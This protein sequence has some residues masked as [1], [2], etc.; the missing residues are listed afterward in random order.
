MKGLESNT[1]ECLESFLSQAYQP[2]QVI[3][4]VRDPED[5]VVGLLRELQQTHP[6]LA[7]DLVF[8]PET[9]GLNPKISS[10]RQMEAAGRA[11]TC[12]SLPTPTSRWGRISSP[13]WPRPCRNRGW[14][15]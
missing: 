11:T 8:C 6:G 5:P 2:Y 9:L 1:R 15:W 12:W 7:T 13:G 10:L 4:G 3:F 14:A